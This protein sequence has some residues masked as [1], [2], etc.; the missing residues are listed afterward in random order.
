MIEQL[1]NGN[2]SGSGWLF[3]FGTAILIAALSELIF[4]LLKVNLRTPEHQGRLPIPLIRS[5]VWMIFLIIML[6]SPL[7]LNGPFT[8][9]VVFVAFLLMFFITRYFL[10][11]LI[12]GLIFRFQHKFEPGDR[13]QTGDSEGKITRLGK[14]GLFLGTIEGDEQYIPWSAIISKGYSRRPAGSRNHHRF[15]L[16]IDGEK[17]TDEVSRELTAYSASLPWLDPTHPV[18]IHEIRVEEGNTLVDL[19]VFSHSDTNASVITGQ[20]RTRFSKSPEGE[21]TDS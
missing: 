3:W 6:S 18:T 8:F 13:I 1:L 17:N 5:V 20:F 4:R 16:T 2:T 14:T 19:S 21:K 7:P 12:S 9:L 15:T 11:D 10:W